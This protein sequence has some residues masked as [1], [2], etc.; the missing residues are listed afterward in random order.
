[1]NDKRSTRK[2]GAGRGRLLATLIL[3]LVSVAIPLGLFEVVLRSYPQ[4]ISLPVLKE[5]PN[6]LRRE[7]AARLGLPLKQARR[8]IAPAERSDHGPELCLATPDFEW[9]HLL[10]PADRESGAE[11]RIPQDANGFCNPPGKAARK[12]DDIQFIGDSFTWC[13]T[14][15]ADQTFSALL[16]EA[17][18]LTTYDLGFPGIGPYEYLEILKRFGL[19]RSPRMVVMN[20]YEG[21]D[22]R[23]ALRYWEGVE[24]YRAG[25][26]G[27][28]GSGGRSMGLFKRLLVSSYSLSFIKAAVEST[29][30]RITG[31]RIDFHYRVEADG[32]TV[33]MNVANAD[34]D[35]VKNARA[36]EQG[37]VS[38][39]VWDD[40]FAAYVKLAREQGFLPVVT[41]IPSAYTAYAASVRFADP[42]VGSLVKNL[43]RRQREYLAQLAER[44]DFTYIDLT[45]AIQRGVTQ[46]PLAYYPANVHLTRRGH[47]LIANIL[48]PQLEALYR[49]RAGKAP[50]GAGTTDAVR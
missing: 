1:M 17:L 32:Q 41:Y 4:I 50:A 2:G 29:A 48:R 27:D 15:R 14:V 7:I 37:K 12:H 23:D 34:R 11:E 26:V 40:A 13:W 24:K 22:F 5:I 39:S 35:E 8:C 9:I 25:T 46:G 36:L 3:L 20:V 28:G 19:A 21:N 43:S 30:K 18:G 49:D 44:F 10:D 6:P 16:E 31:D 45:P 42:Q 47:E 33:P 38:L